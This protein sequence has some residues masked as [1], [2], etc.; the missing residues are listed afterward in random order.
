[1]GGLSAQMLPPP[2]P[3]ARLDI[4]RAYVEPEGVPTV[5]VPQ[6]ERQMAPPAE[7]A[8]VEGKEGNSRVFPPPKSTLTLRQRILARDAILDIARVADEPAMTPTDSRP[9]ALP[10][11]SR[12]GENLHKRMAGTMC[13]RAEQLRVR[14]GQSETGCT[15][16]TDLSLSRTVMDRNRRA[17]ATAGHCRRLL[18]RW[19]GGNS[20]LETPDR[21]PT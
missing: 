9:P 12:C 16:A 18:W 21:S 8:S 7:R 10:L 6:E 3:S 20:P 15:P 19:W 17:T 5:T 2:C 4:C 11:D 14:R 13:L 1:M